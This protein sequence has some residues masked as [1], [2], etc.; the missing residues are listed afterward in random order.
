MKILQINAVNK[1]SSTGRTTMELAEELRI[2]GH[3]VYNVHPSGP[4]DEFS[5]VIGNKWDHKLHALLSRLFG[6]Q[7][8]FSKYAT[9]NLLN[10]IDKYNPD[11]VHLRNLHGN[12]IILVTDENLAFN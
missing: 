4:V 9:K 10:F 1:L 7:G 2:K 12:Y 6:M 8:Y 11:I 3:E 5:Y